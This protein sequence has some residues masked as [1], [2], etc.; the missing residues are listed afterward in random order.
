MNGIG[1]SIASGLASGVAMSATSAI[2][3]RLPP[4]KRS[5]PRVTG[6]AAPPSG[7]DP[8]ADAIDSLAAIQAYMA[9][10]V[11]PQGATADQLAAAQSAV[12]NLARD[13]IEIQA[14]RSRPASPQVPP[15]VWVSG[16]AATAAA[17]G[18]LALGGVAGWLLRGKKE[19]GAKEER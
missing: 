18:A 8:V 12:S 1:H 9:A 14:Q 3:S 4:V 10:V 17:A 13:L 5:V 2:T 7:I 11:T 16:T 6:V 15:G 19:S